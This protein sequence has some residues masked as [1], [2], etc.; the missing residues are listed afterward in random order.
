MVF[1]EASAQDDMAPLVHI[2]W[3]LSLAWSRTTSLSNFAPNGWR[4]L[5]RA[6]M[7]ESGGNIGPVFT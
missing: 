1:D 5:Y 4:S 2:S 3:T 6:S 7:P